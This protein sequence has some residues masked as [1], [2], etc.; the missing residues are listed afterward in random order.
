MECGTDILEIVGCS[1][2]ILYMQHSA[3]Y[4]IKMCSSTFPPPWPSEHLLTHLTCLLSS[5]AEIEGKAELFSFWMCSGWDNS[6]LEFHWFRLKDDAEK[7][8]R[9]MTECWFSPSFLTGRN[10]GIYQCCCTPMS[11]WPCWPSSL[12]QYLDVSH[13]HMQGTITNMFLNQHTIKSMNITITVT[14]FVL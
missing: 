9:C 14:L 13:P 7:K 4:F 5:A 10:C 11:V 6:I 8:D 1:C 3:V 12:L 2:Y